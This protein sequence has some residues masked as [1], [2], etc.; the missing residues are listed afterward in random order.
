MKDHKLF[1]QDSGSGS[2]PPP[3]PPPPPGVNT[4]ASESASTNSII[5][6]VLGILSWVACGILTAIPA[7]I[8]G[9]SEINKINAGHSPQ[10]GKTMATIGMWLG[11]VNVILWIL[12]IIFVILYFLIVGV[13][14][15]SQ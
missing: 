7:W 10:A 6:L 13:F 1:R 9:K 4:G 3:P 12:V 2:I 8:M 14:I 11:I 5:A 15:F